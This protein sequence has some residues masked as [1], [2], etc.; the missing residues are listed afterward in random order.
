MMEKITERNVDEK[1]REEDRNEVFFIRKL[2]ISC[3]S[4]FSWSVKQTHDMVMM[5]YVVRLNSV[6]NLKSWESLFLFS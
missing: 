6:G 3:V 1:L 4:T 5:N 2:L